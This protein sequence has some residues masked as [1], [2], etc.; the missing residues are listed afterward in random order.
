MALSVGHSM[1]QDAT[2]KLE[3]KW[4]RVRRD[5]DDEMAR[6]FDVEFISPL[7]PR[8]KASLA[9]IGRV[10]DIVAQARRDCE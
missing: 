2:K 10:S 1:L 8:V 7:R 9:A 5:W 4:E 3:I 6:R